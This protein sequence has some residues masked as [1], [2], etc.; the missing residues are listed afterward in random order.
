MLI[1]TVIV[2]KDLNRKVLKEYFFIKGSLDVDAEYFIKK[3]K[4]STSS[5]DNLNFTT[6]IRGLMTPFKFFN[7]D[8]KFDKTII[9][10]IDYL[11]THYK[12]PN[13]RINDSWGFEVRPRE[14]TEFHDHSEA[15]WSGVI[16]LND[17]DQPLEFPEIGEDLKPKKGAFAIF[18][19]FLRHGCTKNKDTVSK[20]GLSFNIE[21]IKNW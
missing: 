19:S 13:Y 11:D 3:I 14:K 10:L 9:P 5:K 12:F 17:C 1:E 16:Y 2:N 8:T 15:L 4:E 20:F 6:N 7:T 18:S 21:E